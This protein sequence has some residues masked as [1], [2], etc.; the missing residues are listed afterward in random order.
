VSRRGRAG[1]PQP[2]RPQDAPDER[3]VHAEAP[4]HGRAV[5]AQVDAVRDGRPRRVLGVAVKACLHPVTR[6]GGR[7]GRLSVWC[8]AVGACG[9]REAHLVLQAPA[10]LLEKLL[11]LHLGRLAVHGERSHAAPWARTLGSLSAPP[12]V[13]GVA[14]HTRLR[15]SCEHKATAPTP[16]ALASRQRLLSPG[17][18]PAL[19]RTCTRP[20]PAANAR[21]GPLRTP[22]ARLPTTSVGSRENASAT[23]RSRSSRHTVTGE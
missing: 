18:R 23:V 14:A 10:R 19:P 15:R 1:M 5:R 6:V 8:T 7:G 2:G 3:D 22:R 13:Q 20:R 11:N 4:V 17:A 12:R 16:T 21:T 9:V